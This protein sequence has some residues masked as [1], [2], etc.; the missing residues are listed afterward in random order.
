MSMKKLLSIITATALALTL[1]SCGRADSRQRFSKTFLELFDTASTIIAYDESQAAFDEKY[2][3]FYA[4][5]AEYDKLYDIYSEYDGMNNLCTVNRLAAQSPVEVDEDII[6]LLEYGREVYELS[7]G[8]VNIC[9]GSVL[10]IW[11]T[12]REEGTQYPQQAKL[13]SMQELEQAAEHTSFDSL[14]LDR[15]SSTVYFTD[16]QLK[17]DVG[18]IAKGYAVRELCAW[19]QEELW[20]DFALSLG[21][22]VYTGGFKGDGKTC[23]SIGIENPDTTSQETLL[24]VSVSNLSVV[25]SGDYQRYY[26]VDG[27]E[28]CHIINTQTLMPSEYFSSVTVICKD[29]A[30]GDALSTTLFNMSLEDGKTLVEGL[31][32]V[33]ALWVDKDYNKSFST[34]FEKYIK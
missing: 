29:S 11:H 2:E 22:N 24:N 23:W 7:N 17:L 8:A 13:P 12:Y 31:D 5:L 16:A 6:N 19:A 27:K 9:F 25:T 32:G 30:L 21:G 15:E 10:S 28:Y 1:C 3:R 20:E 26:T 18:A 14:V 33:E 34:G 4:R